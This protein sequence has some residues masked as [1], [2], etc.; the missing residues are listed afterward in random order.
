MEQDRNYKPE[1]WGGIECTINRVRSRFFDQLEAAGL[2]TT[3]FKDEIA[4]LGLR[5]LR[6]P[7]LWERHQPERST[8]IDWSWTQGQ[9]EFFRDQRI[10]V[11]AGLVHHGSGPSFT[12]LLDPDF[13]E[14]LAEY[15]GKVATQF[16]WLRYYTPVNEPLTTARFSALY[17]LWYPHRTDDR[18]FL[19]A[20]LH[21]LKGVVLS[22]QAIRA[23]NP[24]AQLVQT[25]DL[26]KTYSTE[27]LAYQAQFEN[28]RRWLTYDVLC[29]R[30]REG[31]PLWNYVTRFDL[32]Q[33]LLEFF[34]EHPCQPDTFGFNY[35]VTSERFLD[36]DTKKY[37][38]LKAGGN[39]RHRYVDVEA[40][41]VPVDEPTGVSVLLEEAWER[42]R[43]PMAVTECHL[44]CTREEQLRWFQYIYGSCQAL[45]ER[46]V[47]IQAVTAW[48]LFGSRGWNRL[49]TQPGGD[50]EPGVFDLRG[51]TPRA[52]A[53]TRYVQSLGSGTPPDNFLLNQ[54]GWWQREMRY[55][56]ACV[57]PA[58]EIRAAQTGQEQPLLIIGKR[59]TLGQ[60]F[61]RICQVRGLPYRILSR[62]ECDISSAPSVAAALELYQPWAVVNAAGYVRVDDAER[63]TEACLRDNFE[64]PLQL[65][66]ACR[67]RGIRYMAFSSDLVFDGTKGSAY[68][69]SDAARPLNCYGRSKHLLEQALL[70]RYP[71]AL[72][73]RTS[74]FFGPWDQYNFFHWVQMS[75]EAANPVPVADDMI[76]SPTYVPDLVNAALDLL[77][78][79][80]GGL[81]HLAN[82][83]AFRWS[84]LAYMVAEKLDLDKSLIRP[85][86]AAHMNYAAARPLHSALGSEKAPLLPD[87]PNAFHRYFAEKIRSVELLDQ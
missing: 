27:R 50:Y 37:A 76:V 44:H 53:L 22:M 79:A 66:L 77:I 31:H 36:H 59:G 8:D 80:E 42:Y 32:P 12:N 63:E 74:A 17:G 83:G 47:G 4:S 65:G 62:Q 18:S 30:L 26:G 71:Q 33:G 60:A 72:I 16:P 75:L 3:S 82:G 35:Y 52:T 70:A 48:A 38:P 13:P 85:Q 28:E 67:D 14:L 46:G 58:T 45:A 20:L 57:V 51:G 54:A 40:V 39:G 15:A 2:Y 41:R 10:D 81:W 25:E 7:V 34:Q 24:E 23:V 78:D 87:A 6:F 49:L 9:L 29:G 11:I 56:D 68:V 19:L 84:E 64:G 5:R 61:A 43:R 21:Q 73:I 55:L 1:L 69:E 86:P